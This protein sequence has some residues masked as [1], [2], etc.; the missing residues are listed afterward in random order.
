MEVTTDD[1]VNGLVDLQALNLSE[2]ISLVGDVIQ[3]IC[4]PHYDNDKLNNDD[5]QT[6]KIVYKN[7]RGKTGGR[8][9]GGAVDH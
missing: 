2:I 8:T 9:N 6:S 5:G 4:I 3:V 1:V 7:L